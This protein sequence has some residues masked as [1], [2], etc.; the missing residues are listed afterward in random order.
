MQHPS[1]IKWEKG[2]KQIFDKID[3]CLEDKYGKLF[4]LHPARARRGT[5]ANKKYDGLFNVDSAFS[6]GIGSKYGPG[7]VIE[8]RM[9]TLSKVPK[10]LRNEIESVVADMLKQELA[11]RFP[12]KK[13]HI[14]KD[15][16]VY[17]IYGNLSLGKAY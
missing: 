12:G 7:Y 2:L 11:M 1:L 10:P 13:L 4:P 5:T 6:L 3:D 15:G 14:A 17:R 16:N 9:S 8:V